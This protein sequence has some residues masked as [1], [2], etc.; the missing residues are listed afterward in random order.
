MNADGDIHPRYHVDVF[1]KNTTS[2][3]IGYHRDDELSCFY[4]LVDSKIP[5]KYLTNG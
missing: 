4:S 2:I 3:K 1:Y 5:K